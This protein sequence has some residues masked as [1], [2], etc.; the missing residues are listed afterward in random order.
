MRL[1]VYRGPGA[2]F[3]FPGVDPAGLVAFLN[4]FSLALLFVRVTRFVSPGHVVLH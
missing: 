2:P 4:V 3:R 1:L